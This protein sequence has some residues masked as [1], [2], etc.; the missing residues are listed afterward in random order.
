M[1][2]FTTYARNAM[3]DYVC[4]DSPPSI[5]GVWL[6]VSTTTP[7]NAGTNVTEP[8]G[9]NYSRVQ[10]TSGVWSA[11]SSGSKQNNAL[12]SFPTASGSWGTL[13]H[14]V[15]YDAVTGGNALAWGPLS[16][17]QTIGNGQTLEIAAGQLTLAIND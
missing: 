14:G 16:P 3:L 15:L 7:T 5:T 17:N 8:S 2:A 9:N 1:S 11:A 13:T 12:I 4:A 10:V 6:A